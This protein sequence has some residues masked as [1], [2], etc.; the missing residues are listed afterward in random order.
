MVGGGLRLKLLELQFDGG[1]I[2]VDRF[3][4]QAHLLA[5]ELFAAPAKLLAFEDG[6][7]VA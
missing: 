5:G 2:G 4:Q 1:Q 6:Y 7:L 3:V